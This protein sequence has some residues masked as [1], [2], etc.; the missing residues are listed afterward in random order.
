MLRIKLLIISLLLIS[1]S[2]TAQNYWQPQTITSFLVQPNTQV[3]SFVD[4]NGIH[5]AYY[6]NGGIKYALVNSNG[7]AINGKYD[8]VIESEGAGANYVNVAAIDNNVYVFYLKNNKIQVA[9]STNLGDTWNNNFDNRPMTNYGCEAVTG[10]LVGQE[11]HIIWTENRVNDYQPETHYIKFVP[12]LSVN[13]WINYYRVTDLET[14]GGNK[15]DLAISTDK[16]H[17][18]Y[19]PPYPMN[20]KSRTRLANGTWDTPQNVPYYQFPLASLTQKVKPII[21]GS[22]LNEI[23]R[24][25]YGTIGVDGSYIGHS[26]RPLTG[27]TWTQNPNIINTVSGKS[28]LVEK[29]ADNKIHI[30]SFDESSNNYVHR[31]I[32][33]TTISDIITTVPFYE[34][35]KKL[36]ANS[37]DLYLIHTGNTSTPAQIFFRQYDAIPLAPQNLT[38]STST[39]NHPLLSWTKNNEADLDHYNIYKKSYDELNYQF[40]TSTASNSYEDPNETYLLPGQNGL[41]HYVHYKITAVDKHPYESA[42]SNE[43]HTRLGGAYLD[44]QYSGNIQVADYSLD[45]NYPNPFNPAT[46]IS[47]SIKEEGLVTLKVYDVLG[48][49]IATLVNENKPEGNYEVDFNASQLPSG[50][51]IYKLQSGGFSDVKKMLLTK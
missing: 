16:V 20:P 25:N 41:T 19:V 26:Y 28:H 5:I 37:N 39:N 12:N 46:K 22:N 14:E 47:Y 23:Y 44:K 29:T 51:Y 42:Y 8:K 36:T 34:L 32:S 9:K 45:Q 35:S 13:R 48:K 15:S 1:V 33:G 3:T 17:V 7:T 4:G 27:S 31:T 21:T 11:I 38:V 18:D 30:I 10:Y 6:R 49:E 43:V 40:L 24:A 2:I 50:M